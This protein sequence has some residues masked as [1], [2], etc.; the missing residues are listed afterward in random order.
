MEHNVYC[1]DWNHWSALTDGQFKFIFHASTGQEQLF[2]LTADPQESRDLANDAQWAPVLQLWRLRL[3]QQFEEERRGPE[4][5]VNGQLV[6]RRPCNYSPNY[7][8]PHS[9]AFRSD[10]NRD[11]PERSILDSVVI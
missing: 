4:W 2:N 6:R 5:V 9:K 3:V 1:G 10:G 11:V 7:P 8:G